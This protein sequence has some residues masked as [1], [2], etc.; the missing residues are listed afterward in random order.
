MMMKISLL[1]L[2]FSSTVSVQGS[3]LSRIYNYINVYYTWE[4]AQAYCRR[5]SYYTDLALFYTESDRDQEL[6]YYYNVWVGLE[7]IN[8]DWTWT[9]GGKLNS[10]E[11]GPN[12]THSFQTCAYYDHLRKRMYG[13]SCETRYFFI[14]YD[15]S[16]NNYRFISRAMSQPDAAQYCRTHHKG[17]APFPNV[18]DMRSRI[19]NENFPAWIGLHSDGDDWV[20]SAGLSDYRGWGLNGP[21][22]GGGCVTLLS[23]SKQMVTRDC[24]ERLPFLCYRDNLILVKENKTWEEA[25]DHCRSITSE[26]WELISVQPGSE[27]EVVIAS[28]M[29]AD[30]EEV[31]SGLRFMEGFWW[32]VDGAVMLYSDLP[33]C[34][35]DWRHCGALSKNDTVSLKPRDCLEKK[36]FLCYRY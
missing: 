25:L 30:T 15:N 6:F 32:W 35:R 22:D 23:E 36:N 5:H 26:R 14:C 13:S 8:N 7:K 19:H 24:S 34:P 12:E 16:G 9:Q 17:L 33:G 18:L 28:I 29:G 3:V 11:L 27:H 2:L 1:L 21:G 20:W 31:W 10:L 4:E